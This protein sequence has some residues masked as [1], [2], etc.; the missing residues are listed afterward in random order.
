MCVRRDVNA[1]GSKKERRQGCADE[2]E[3]EGVLKG[4]WRHI[5]TE[6]NIYKKLQYLT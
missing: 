1:D 6:M 5:Q 2:W 4:S 3:E